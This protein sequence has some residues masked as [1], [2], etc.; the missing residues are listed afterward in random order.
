MMMETI[1]NWCYY[2]S[3]AV[4]GLRQRD[5]VN[6]IGGILSYALTVRGSG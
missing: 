2:V 1:S 6:F 3:G 5:A 4:P